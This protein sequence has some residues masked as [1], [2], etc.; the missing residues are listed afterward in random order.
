MHLKVGDCCDLPYEDDMFAA[1]T[2]INTVYFW[3]DTVKGLSEIR[4]TLKK[5]KSFYNIVYTKEYL[6]TIKYTQIGYK[7]FEPEELIEYGKQAGFGSIELKEIIS[8]KS[9]GVIYTK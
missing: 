5:G 1:V 8:G 9:Y 6:N 7:K 3:T 2:S 4:R